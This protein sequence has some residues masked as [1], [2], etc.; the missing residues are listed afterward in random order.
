MNKEVQSDAQKLISYSVS[1]AEKLLLEFGEYYPFAAKVELSGDL[2]PFGIHEGE[3][4]PESQKVINELTAFLEDELNGSKIRAYC[5]SYDVR[6]TNEKYSSSID[7]VLISFRHK[8]VKGML[9]YYYPY[10]I[11]TDKK[12][13]FK[14][15]WGEQEK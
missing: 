3:E 15:P 1:F 5:I 12:I 6:V 14:E 11:D 8:G 9:N 2:T 7:T 4:Y 10:I 13:E